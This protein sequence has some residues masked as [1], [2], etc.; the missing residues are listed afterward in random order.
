VSDAVR[1]GSAP[2]ERLGLGSHLNHEILGHALELEA[3]TLLGRTALVLELEVGDENL[4]PP[5]SSTL[6]SPL[7]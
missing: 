5:G 6:G 4:A 7:F 2:I 1:I 3:V